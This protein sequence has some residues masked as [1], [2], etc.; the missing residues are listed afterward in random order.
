MQ[1]PTLPT[2]ASSRVVGEVMDSGS[3]PAWKFSRVGSRPEC[4][5]SVLRGVAPVTMSAP[6]M[7]VVLPSTLAHLSAPMPG[8][9]QVVM[10]TG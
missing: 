3:R 6:A 8:T 9:I 2:K 4:I 10:A 5:R 7:V 1:P